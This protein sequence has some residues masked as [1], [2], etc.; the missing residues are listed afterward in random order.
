MAMRIYTREEFF[1]ELRKRGCRRHGENIV[2]KHMV[3]QNHSG[4]VF[5]LEDSAEYP[6]Y[7]LDRLI[8]HCGV[9]SS[10]QQTQ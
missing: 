5:L 6:D 1:E 7:I 2:R 9:N 10:P 8:K 3:W 4:D